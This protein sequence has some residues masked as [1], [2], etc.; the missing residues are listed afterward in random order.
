VQVSRK[1][2]AV[3][4]LIAM[5][6]LVIGALLKPE[7]PEPPP[8]QP[9]DTA[10]LRRPLRSEAM[11]ETVAYLAER[12]AAVAPAVVRLNESD[13]SGVVWRH[14]EVVSAARRADAGMPLESFLIPD[15]TNVARSWN[16][17]PAAPS[18]LLIVARDREAKSMWSPAIYEGQSGATCAGT[19]YDQLRIGALPEGEFD[20]AGIFDLDGNLI[21]I[22]ARCMENQV[23]IKAASIPALLAKAQ[24]IESRLLDRFGF[25]PVLA[26]AVAGEAF[27][28]E[29]GV[30]VRSVWQGSAADLA[31]L[32]PGDVI[33][34]VE[35]RAL[36]RIA[37][38]EVLLNRNGETGLELSRT[39]RRLRVS[40][41]NPPGPEPSTGLGIRVDTA[42]AIDVSVG[43]NSPAYLAGMRTGDGVI[44][45]GAIRNPSRAQVERALARNTPDPL[46]IVY[47]RGL[48]QTGVFLSQ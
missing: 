1:Y 36:S 6:I 19:S 4:A 41:N 35:G 13:A 38:L 30:L 17:S 47:Q 37:G 39:G 18:V 32:R 22:V 23:A 9:S 25:E 15:A 8:P 43:V 16:A 5:A 40:L 12:A 48:K 21:G 14:G 44:Q 42:S 31:D 29:G 28:A 34:A 27:G 24:S 10:S 2:I 45:I 11:R 33:T 7:A 26:D 46:F 3:L 20:G